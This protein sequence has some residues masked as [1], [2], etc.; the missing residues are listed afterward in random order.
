LAS[1][2]GNQREDAALVKRLV[3]FCK[4]MALK[5]ATMPIKDVVDAIEGAFAVIDSNHQPFTVKERNYLELHL[6]VSL[7]NLLFNID[8]KAFKAITGRRLPADQ[9]MLTVS[10]MESTL[11]LAVDF[12]YFQK[13]RHLET[14]DFSCHPN[15]YY[16]PILSTEL[17][18]SEYLLE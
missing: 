13:G 8:A 1:Q 7:H 4:G 15:Q 12:F 6:L 11:S 3:L 10:A 18:C 5:I 9:P 14:R 16:H 17:E 2:G